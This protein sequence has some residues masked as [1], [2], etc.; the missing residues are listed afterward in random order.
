MKNQEIQDKISMIKKL[1]TQNES[2]R[3]QIARM[4]EK[5]IRNSRGNYTKKFNNL[6]DW[7]E[8]VDNAIRELRNEIKN[9][10]I[11]LGVKECN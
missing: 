6:V 3:N 8:S 10:L 11:M 5:E 2:K 4:P 9:Y 1:E 7:I